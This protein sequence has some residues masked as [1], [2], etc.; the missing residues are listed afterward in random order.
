MIH[1]EHFTNSDFD[2]FEIEDFEARMDRIRKCISP[3]LKVLG[4]FFAP[5]LSALANQPLYPRIALHMR[6]RVNPPEETWVAFSPDPKS[7]K[8]FV[9]LRLAIEVH[10]I[11]YLCFLEAESKDK[12]AFAH[13]IR[14]HASFLLDYFKSNP[15]IICFNIPSA[16]GTPI[17][18]K[19]LNLEQLLAFAERLS[20]VKNQHAVFGLLL[21]RNSEEVTQTERFLEVSTKNLAKTLPLFHLLDM[22]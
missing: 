15:A 2:I 22:D 6:R 12:I 13:A 5:E 4:E 9:H 14:S 18:G 19:D 8:P 3:K 10:G 16:D 17:H 1:W 7:Y 20:V 11:R 21:P